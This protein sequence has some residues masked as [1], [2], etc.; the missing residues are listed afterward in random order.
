M[1]SKM[2]CPQDAPRR[3]QDA[4]RRPQDAPGRAQ[5]APRGAQDAPK[6]QHNWDKNPPQNAFPSRSGF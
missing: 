3:S 2:G 1:P 4:P 6:T 5:D